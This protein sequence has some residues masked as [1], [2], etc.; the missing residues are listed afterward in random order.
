MGKWIIGLV[1]ALVIA[2]GGAF[3][4][5]KG[6][7]SPDTATSK[8]TETSSSTTPTPAPTTDSGATSPQPAA[9]TAAVEIRDFAFSPST[10]KVK[11]GTKVT[12]TNQDSTRHDVASTSD[13]PLK[14]LAGPLLA[15]GQSYSFTFNEVGTYKY[16]CTPHASQMRGTVEVTE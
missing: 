16:L 8:S 12:W 6:Q 3:V 14:G 13:S 10:L 1:I 11:K 5:M 2:I 7:T 9:T 15:K 4:L